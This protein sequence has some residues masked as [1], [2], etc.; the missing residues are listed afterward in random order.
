MTKLLSEFYKVIVIST[1]QV[2]K[3]DID[4]APF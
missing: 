1:K 2:K 3:I 4:I